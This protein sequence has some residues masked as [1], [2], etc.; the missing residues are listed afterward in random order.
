MTAT[1][2]P[3]RL[4]AALAGAVV[5]MALA[6]AS[7]SALSCLT[8]P[9]GSFESEDAA[10]VGQ[11]IERG[12]ETAVMA[13]LEGFKGVAT[14]EVVEI[15]TGRA[16]PPPSMTA[17]LTEVG[18]VT[19]VFASRLDH[20]RLATSVCRG[21][22]PELMR[23]A[24]AIA[25]QGRTCTGEQP[26]IIWAVPQVRGRELTLRVVVADGRERAHTVRVVWGAQF[27]VEGNP[28]TVARVPRSHTLLLRHRYPRTGDIVVRVT[29]E[30]RPPLLCGA[31]PEGLRDLR[32]SLPVRRAAVRR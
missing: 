5:V 6:P 7:A 2:P 15:V 12:E 27:G 4:A 10:F 21:A 11:V 18:H 24:A 22:S 17:V 20:G 14:G 30:P 28:E 32:I 13:V 9:L 8:S 23:L 16:E 3:A 29:V 19:G 31:R 26:R 25:A 1:R